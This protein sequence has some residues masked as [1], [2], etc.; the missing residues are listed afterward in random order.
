MFWLFDTGS[1]LLTSVALVLGLAIV[2][3]ATI[4]VSAALLSEVFPTRLRWSGIAI[5]REIPAAIF[6]G[7]APFVATWLVTVGGGSPDLVAW[8]LVGVT[9]VGLIGILALPE[10]LPKDERQTVTRYGRRPPSP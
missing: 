3:G 6:G 9:V 2:Q 7:T 4:G 1:V 10:T 8:Y 5:S